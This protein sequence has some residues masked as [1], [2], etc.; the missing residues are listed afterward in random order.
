MTF[1]EY[2]TALKIDTFAG[3]RFALPAY[4]PD[5]VKIDS[6]KERQDAKKGKTTE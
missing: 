6:R 1:P 5:T 3:C 2:K 4:N